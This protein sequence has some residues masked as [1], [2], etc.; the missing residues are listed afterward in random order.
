MQEDFRKNLFT[1]KQF[2]KKDFPKRKWAKLSDNL[3]KMI[4]DDCS[5]ND[6]VKAYIENNV[7][8]IDDYKDILITRIFHEN[9]YDVYYFS[10]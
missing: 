10:F 4:N 9:N 8:I 2:I 1:Y 7:K 5:Y 6:Y 3:M